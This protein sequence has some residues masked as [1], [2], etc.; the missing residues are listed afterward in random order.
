MTY[1]LLSDIHAHAWSAFSTRLPCGRNSRLQIIVDELKRAAAET[2]AAGGSLLV[3]GGD[4]FHTRGSIDPEVFNPI[5]DAVDEILQAGVSIVALAGN[6]DLKSNESTELGN[7]F[8][9]FGKRKGFDVV[10]YPKPRVYPGVKLLMVPWIP[11]LDD[12]KRDLEASANALGDDRAE[13]D[14]VMHAGIDGVLSGMPAHGLTPAYLAELG[15]KRVFAGHYHHHCSFEDG[16]VWSIGATTHQTASDIGTKAGFLLVDDAVTY[17]ASRAPEFVEVTDE[18]D[19]DLIPEI[20]DGNYVRVR[21]L[22]LSAADE[23]NLREEL[24]RLGA[25]GVVMNV[26]R[27]TTSARVSA[28][29][30]KAKTLEVSVA[31][32]IERQGSPH[33]DAVKARAAAIISAVRAA[34]E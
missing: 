13:F 29:S 8:Q 14:L 7:A 3:I 4:V 21:G 2:Q 22:K 17:R 18:T 30:V 5:S 20:V 12:L 26:E 11:K 33:K 28:P 34:T 31:D 23:V 10:T 24:V 25:K 32:Y 9:S 15:F 6:H 1:S 27:E 19:P 16:K